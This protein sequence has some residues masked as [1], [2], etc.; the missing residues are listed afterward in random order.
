MTDDPPLVEYLDEWDE[1]RPPR[2]PRRGNGRILLLSG[3]VVV[4]AVVL[5]VALGT[6]QRRAVDPLDPVAPVTSMMPT[7]A[8]TNSA[9]AART[10]VV[11]D[12]AP[13]AYMSFVADETTEATRPAPLGSDVETDP[14]TISVL[15]KAPKV[16]GDAVAYRLKACVNSAS[17]GGGKVRILRD[18]W[19][20]A[21]FE[22]MSGPAPD[23]V[24]IEP[25]F[26]VDGLYAK[27]QCATGYVTF[28][29]GAGTPMWL[30][31]SDERF[32]WVWRV[33]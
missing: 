33:T 14:L 24:P 28:S 21:T 20:L 1:P 16:S 10:Y 29:I 2:P 9:T 5:A 25:A 6:R 26:P 12:D 19:Q 22:G 4:V 23:I 3:L 13:S 7:A 17:V 15:D 27:G 30:T 11:T 32:Q 18:S 31:F 8:P